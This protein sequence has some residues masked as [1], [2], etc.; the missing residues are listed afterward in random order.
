MNTRLDIITLSSVIGVP[1]CNLTTLSS[2]IFT[3]I[4]LVFSLMQHF[5]YAD[6][7][8]KLFNVSLRDVSHHQDS[9]VK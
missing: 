6:T 9:M 5:A 2:R 1:S 4:F 8:L 3:K 7:N